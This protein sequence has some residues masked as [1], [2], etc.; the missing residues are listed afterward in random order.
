MLTPAAWRMQ[1]PSNK[2]KLDA[3]AR[4]KRMGLDAFR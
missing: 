4:L 1:M 2:A 3:G